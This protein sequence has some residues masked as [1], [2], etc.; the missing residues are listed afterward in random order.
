MV[1]RLGSLAGSLMIL[2]CGCATEPLPG[3]AGE[4]SGQLRTIELYTK[5]PE[6]GEQYRTATRERLFASDRR[7]YVNSMWDLPGPGD[8]VTKAIL[9]TPSRVRLSGE[10]V[11]L[12]SR[13][14]LLVY[15]PPLRSSPRGG[16]PRPR[17][18]LAG[19][20]NPRRRARWSAGLHI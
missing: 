9:H 8:Y 13:G 14:S 4:V 19:R 10:G 6:R 15:V 20:S 1:L 2:V 18:P 16:E 17:R 5:R 3:A 12:S 11:P 7:V